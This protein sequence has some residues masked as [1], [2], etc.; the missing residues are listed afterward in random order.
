MLKQGEGYPAHVRMVLLSHAHSCG[1]AIDRRCGHAKLHNEVEEEK[2]LSNMRPCDWKY[3]KVLESRAGK[4]VGDYVDESWEVVYWVKDRAIA[5][6]GKN[7]PICC[8]RPSGEARR[9]A[10]T[11]VDT[12]TRT[13]AAA[14]NE[15]AI[16]QASAIGD[17][18]K[19]KTE[20]A[21]GRHARR[22]EAEA[23]KRL[24]HGGVASSSG[25]HYQ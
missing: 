13:D 11:I 16:A 4:S 24:A 6:D 15:N 17:E 3:W 12:Q 20:K 10:V 14:E 8:S 22:K 2:T 7:G 21:I 18:P 25:Y 5:F 1:Y 9:T 23:R 19:V